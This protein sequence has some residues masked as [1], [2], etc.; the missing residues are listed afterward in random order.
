LQR[1]R[2][3]FNDLLGALGVPRIV[4]FHLPGGVY[5]TRRQHAGGDLVFLMNFGERD[6]TVETGGR[7]YESVPDGAKISKGVSLPRFGLSIL[8]EC[9]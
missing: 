5:A 4:P 9:Q 2:P 3:F 6:V 8:R 1:L 7:K